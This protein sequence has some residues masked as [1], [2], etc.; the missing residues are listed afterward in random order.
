MGRKL[1]GVKNL[2]LDFF[3]PDY[4]E[5]ILFLY[6]LVCILFA[7]VYAVPFIESA[8]FSLRGVSLSDFLT[9]LL[10]LL[11]VILL[12]LLPVYHAFSKKPKRNWEKWGMLF[13]IIFLNYLIAWS[14]Y[15]Y[16]KGSFTSWEWIFP[17][18]NALLATL[19]F[20]G[21]WFGFVTISKISDQQA[22]LQEI[23]ISSMVVTGLFLFCHFRLHTYWAVTFSIC[24]FYSTLINKLIFLAIYS[25]RFIPMKPKP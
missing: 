25:A 16:L 19:Y 4:D 17:G 9:D 10:L 20:F 2:L 23:I 12:I 21:W 15:D 5:L 18:F 22:S 7:I 24:I 11:S 6:S 13:S 14:T 8:S 1:T 3:F